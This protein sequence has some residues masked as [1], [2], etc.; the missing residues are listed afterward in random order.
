MLLRVIISHSG[1]D[2]SNALALA[3]Q[4]CLLVQDHYLPVQFR[5]R[6]NEALGSKRTCLPPPS[7]VTERRTQISEL[8]P[9]GQLWIVS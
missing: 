6:G 9:S 8:P 4:T 1:K 7:H 2:Q 5:P 3:G